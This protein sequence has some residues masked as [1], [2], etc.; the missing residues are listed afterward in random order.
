MGQRV[1]WPYSPVVEIFP[2]VLGQNH[3]QVINVMVFIRRDPWRKGK[4]ESEQ[5]NSTAG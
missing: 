3:N 4:R 5:Q 1:K 2:H